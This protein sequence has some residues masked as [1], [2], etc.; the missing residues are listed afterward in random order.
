MR[1]WESKGGR[2]KRGLCTRVVS[3][4]ATRRR[5]LTAARAASADADEDLVDAV[6]NAEKAVL[7]VADGAPYGGLMPLGELLIQV[8]AAVEEAE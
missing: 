5:L 4:H 1:A 3:E 2:G 7:K 6:A 8:L